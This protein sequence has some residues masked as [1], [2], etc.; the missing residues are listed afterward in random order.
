MKFK[1]LS[2]LILS[3]TFFSG[4]GQNANDNSIETTTDI[5]ENVSDNSTNINVTAENAIETFNNSVD[6]FFNLQSYNV[7]ADTNLTVTSGNKSG[8]MDMSATIKMKKDSNNK[9]CAELNTVFDMAGT[10]EEVKGYYKEDYYYKDSKQKVKADYS[11]VLA[12]G[13]VNIFKITDNMI[14][15]SVQP[16]VKKVEEGFRMDFDLNVAVLQKEAPDFVPKLANYL[17]V[18]E[19]DFIMSRFQSVAIVGDDGL[20]KALTYIIKASDTIYDG[21]NDKN[22]KSFPVDCD[23]EVTVNV[24]DV[25]NADFD[26]PQDLDSYSD[27]TPKTTEN[28]TN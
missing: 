3:A 9:E 22:F 16:T 14:N 12:E 11:N 19:Y 5:V 28:T 20:L 23:I 17:R 4:C 1:L 8:N 10:K 27:V 18:S 21:T 6:T 13:N 15:N 24:S 25:N 26:L 2:A 7:S